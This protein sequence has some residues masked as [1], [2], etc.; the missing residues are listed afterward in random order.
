MQ[1]YRVYVN[2][3]NYSSWELYD[4]IELVKKTADIRPFESKL[5][6]NDVFTLDNNNEVQLVHSTVRSGTP[7][8]GV[9]IIHGNKTYGRG[10]NG[11]GLRWLMR[12]GTRYPI[13]RFR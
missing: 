5:F 7:M 9:L 12:V 4:T 6:S 3:R 8:P 1:A 10:K 2:D 11:K 13:H